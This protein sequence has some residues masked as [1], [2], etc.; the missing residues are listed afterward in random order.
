MNYPIL[1]TGLLLVMVAAYPVCAAD[2][3]DVPID[4]V[5]I[6][7]E[8]ADPQ[9]TDGKSPWTS[10]TFITPARMASSILDSPNSVTSLDTTTLLKL[11]ITDMVDALRLVP[12]M[13]VSESHASD[14]SV[15]YHGANVNIPR[16]SEVL[17]NSNRLY[18]PGYAGAHWARL[19]VDIQ[20]LNFIEVVRGSSPEYG[21]N[22]MTSTVNLIQDS[23]AT[24]GAYGFTR[25][26]DADT[27]DVF[28]KTGYQLGNAQLGL[29]V[30]RR[31]NDGFDGVVGSDRPYTNDLITSSVMVNV[32][33]PLNN[34]WLLDVA[35]SY[36]DS[37]YQFP[38]FEQLPSSGSTEDLAL[39]GFQPSPDVDEVSS[40]ISSKVHGQVRLAET[41][42][43]ITLGLNYSHFSRDQ[44]ISTCGPNFSYDPRL[45]ELD[46]LPS[47][48]LSQDDFPLAL[49]A[50]A[51]GIFELNASY[52]Q[53]PSP[54]EVQAVADLGP[55]L[56]SIGFAMLDTRCGATDQDLDEDRFEFNGVIVSDLSDRLENSLGLTVTHNRVS[57]RTYLGGTVTQDSVQLTDTLRYR[58][59]DRLVTSATVAFE[60][61]ENVDT[62]DALSYR[63]AINYELAPGWVVRLT[64]SRA[65]RLPDVYETDRDWTFRFQYL[66]G[67]T[68]HLGR[69]QGTLLRRAMSPDNLASERLDS[70]ELTLAYSVF[71]HATADVKVFYEDFTGLISEPFN[72]FDFRLTNNGELTNRGVEFGLRFNTESGIDWGA[73]Y[74][75]MNSD[76]DTPF[77][78]SLRKRHSGSLWGIFPVAK[79]TDF[80]AV[81]YGASTVGQSS[82]DRFDLTLTHRHPW[83]R[84]NLDVQLNYRRYPDGINAFT[85]FSDTVPV[86]SFIEGRNRFF[87][88]AA[89]SFY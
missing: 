43:E 14:V 44:S 49:R 84:G 20:D 45:A 41:E 83:S 4:P 46:A 60:T 3:V 67:E 32:E 58:W 23:A 88:T 7:P 37:A 24:R 34:Q 13:M 71:D 59:N 36:A 1:H 19:P 16:R 29:R 17:Y 64:Q 73:S 76:S 68:D 85:G 78:T 18:R 10:A 54:E 57:A 47:I 38:G 81:Y 8:S 2:L 87:L 65:E 56:Q 22:A 75:Y 9:S 80:A 25:L 48:S 39:E 40:F 15:G 11:G 31:Q 55:Y 86:S 27:R 69:T 42:H 66:P 72:F 51:T 77:E 70:T 61:A 62:S 6:D 35:A 5:A 12:G 52:I 28:L 50:L 21:S 63:A 79:N 89:L 74:T 33:L 82:Y 30:L 26:G 53:T